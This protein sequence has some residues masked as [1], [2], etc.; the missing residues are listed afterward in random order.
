MAPP[1]RRP[2]HPEMA[3]NKSAWLWIPAL[4][5][6]VVLAL[7]HGMPAQLWQRLQPLPQQPR[8][9]EQHLN[10]L[11]TEQEQA[12]AQEQACNR[13]EE[14]LVQ[15]R[16]TQ[17]RDELVRFER[18]LGCERL[19]PQLLRLRESIFAEA[20]RSERDIAQQPQAEQ[21]HPKSDTVRPTPERD[22]SAKGPPT[23]ISQDQ[24]CKRDA[25][26]LARLRVS[27]AHDEVIR[28]ERELGCEKLRPQVVRLRG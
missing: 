12:V 17:A 3:M 8:Q 10:S 18:E 6:G 2:E 23:S 24:I 15:L 19:R 20:E 25:E 9:Q 13:D 22:A 5:G 28:F 21:Q 11:V 14:R 26:R 16:A 27:Q 4:C 7:S 1:A